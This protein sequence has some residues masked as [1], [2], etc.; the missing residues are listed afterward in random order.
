MTQAQR[1]YTRSGLY[2]L[3]LGY[4]DCESIYV[5]QGKSPYSYVRGTC[6]HCGAELED[7]DAVRC[8]DCHRRQCHYC[9]RV[10]KS[11]VTIAHTPETYEPVKVGSSCGCLRRE[12]AFRGWLLGDLL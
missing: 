7:S 4:D 8:E 12:L 11:T 9:G 1:H 5:P 10:C 3:S 2:W 6:E